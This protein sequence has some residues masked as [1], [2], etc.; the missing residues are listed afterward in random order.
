GMFKGRPAIFGAAAI[1][2]EK[3]TDPAP[4][5]DLRYIVYVKPID[6][7]LLDLWSSNFHIEGLDWSPKRP[8]DPKLGVMAL[9][10]PD[11]SSCGF[12]FWT[13]P[14]PGSGALV[15]SLPL[16][17]T[18]ALLMLVLAGASVRFVMKTS[19]D[20]QHGATIAQDNAAKAEQATAHA[21]EAA[22]SAKIALERSESDRRQIA[23]MAKREAAEQ[24]HHTRQL[25][26]AASS[27]GN[28]IE[29]AVSTIV[30][31]LL[32]TANELRDSADLTMNVITGQ[33]RHAK[34]IHDQSREATGL[35]AGVI[36]GIRTISSALGDVSDDTDENR[37]LLTVAGN[38]SNVTREASQE[39]CDRVGEI[40]HAAM[41]I[42]TIT[43]QT[44]MLALNA[45]IEAARAG[46]DGR[47][48]AVV[49]TEVKSLAGQTSALNG[50][51]QASVANAETTAR[52]SL[53]LTEA[54]CGTL[55]ELVQSAS[56]TLK[57]LDD[58]R[59]AARELSDASRLVENYSGVV[60]TG[61]SALIESID[62]IAVRA[63]VTRKVGAAVRQRAELL[64]AE[65]SYFIAELRSG[66]SA[67][68]GV[69]AR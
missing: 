69:V 38:Q 68:I 42:S 64:Q 44:S 62:D 9:T 24:A 47:G 2:P 59:R 27:I 3:P 66:S 37:R 34:L 32:I 57:T 19:R 67:A 52:S 55:A 45:T 13:N 28:G 8:S 17:I 60:L 20:L 21:E 61:T 41:H 7:R 58:Q 56:T 4:R 16:V 51:V 11:G 63:E 46:E 48:F 50:T 54:M 43:R 29:Q 18:A 40:K 39:L 35:V 23:E 22:A 33:Q 6:R 1:I 14:A 15:E 36:D 30:T 25:Q 31:D 5:G 53:D 10:A 26:A 65:L 12:L 49:A